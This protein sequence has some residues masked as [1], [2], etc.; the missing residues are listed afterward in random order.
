MNP[1]YGN[2]NSIVHS[3]DLFPDPPGKPKFKEEIGEW[4][5]DWLKENIIE[6]TKWIGNHPFLFILGNHDH[7]DPFKV[8][9]L[10]RSYNIK[11]DCLH[12][13]IVCHNGINFYGIPYIPYIN[14]SFAY[15]L[16]SDE[17]I[18]EINQIV[19]KINTAH[20]S[21]LINVLVAHAPPYEILD[22]SYSGSH[23]GN[24][25]MTEAFN[26]KIKKNRLPEY[27]L[28]GHVHHSNGILLKND[29]LYSNAAT[30]KHIIEI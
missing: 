12:D 18:K 14:G 2:F 4:Q 11:I 26:N 24:T 10:L 15:E 22:L 29:T 23:L 16:Q 25:V 13:S 21:S 28:T 8:E 3:G 7:A 1:L 5:L 9:D 19:K 6:F 17:M 30:T 20:H 27:Y